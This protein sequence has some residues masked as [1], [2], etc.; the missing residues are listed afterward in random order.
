MLIPTLT[1]LFFPKQI[2]ES[3]LAE[4]K[5]VLIPGLPD[6][7]WTAEWMKYVNNPE[8]E[9]QKSAVGNSLKNLLIKMCSMAEYQ[10]M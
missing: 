4:L 3:Q 7:E 2:T 10:L 5:D 9:N 6:F 1:A 8:D